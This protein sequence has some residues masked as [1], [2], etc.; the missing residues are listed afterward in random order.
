MIRAVALVAA[1]GF[2]GV[3]HAEDEQCT[4]Y[5][6]VQLTADVAS[7]V[8][9]M[10]TADLD[11]MNQT[12]EMISDKL[13]CLDELV[14]AEQ[15]ATFARYM[16]LSAFFDQDEIVATQWGLS[17]REA[18]Q[19]LAWGDTFA[20]DHPFRE[21]LTTV[22]DNPVS[23]KDGVALAIPKGGGIFANGVLLF[24]PKLRAET[25]YLLQVVEKDGS[26]T[27]A[28]WQDGAAFSEDLLTA[29]LPFGYKPPR[30]YDG[31]A[32]EV[33]LHL[34]EQKE[35]FPLIKVA[36]MSGLAVVAGTLYG[37]ATLT[38]G[39]MAKATTEDELLSA[40]STTNLLV[41]TSGL[42]GAAAVGVGV[43]VLVDGKSVGLSVRF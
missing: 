26:I 11:G 31:M 28:V 17:S 33:P 24:E 14:D 43:A 29:D 7:A 4:G 13:P 30:W 12:L 40:R 8:A 3:A 18:V 1:I 42:A 23:V 10:S 15:F 39:G 16:A 19:K 38:E 21:L 9:S 27:S 37:V 22:E 41:V 6:N 34:V 36:T 20:A 32:P 35:P 2:A 25:N 5:D